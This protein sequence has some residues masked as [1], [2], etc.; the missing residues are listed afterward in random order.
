MPE[1]R[2][3]APEG[4]EAVRA[5]IIEVAGRHFATYGT[6]ASL[7]DIAKEAQVNLGLIHRHIG[8]K[9]DLL[10]A[11][12]ESRRDVGLSIAESTPGAGD[13]VRQIFTATAENG[14]SV[15]TMAWLLLAGEYRERFPSDFPTITAL[16]GRLEGDEARLH[17]LAA[18][19]MM[20]GWTVFGEQ[21]VE[22]FGYVDETKHSL[23]PQLAQLAG[24][25]VERP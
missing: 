9:D 10:Q 6:R 25:I 7:R 22:A 12:L 8:N 2:A 11:V 24:D 15:R 23:T 18:F 4:R 20:Y 16:Q 3:T 5:A 13:A 21:L 17:L 14:V 19:S 1:I